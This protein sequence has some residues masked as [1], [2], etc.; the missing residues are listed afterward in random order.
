MLH[1]DPALDGSVIGTMG[2]AASDPESPL[3]EEDQALFSRYFD[4]TPRNMYPDERILAYNPS[5]G[6]DF[7]SMVTGDR[8]AQHCVLMCGSIAVAL[9][10]RT[11]PKDLA[12]HISKICAILNR[13]LNQQSAVDAVTLHCIA[14]LACVGVCMA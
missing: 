10:T 3:S 7:Y 8:A 9:E 14:K 11:E 6:A 4:C 12:Y 1:I 5:R 2:D 13:K